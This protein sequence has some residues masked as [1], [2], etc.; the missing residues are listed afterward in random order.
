MNF[1]KKQEEY[2]KKVLLENQY[3][4]ENVLLVPSSRPDLG[5]YQ[6][7][8]MMALAKKKG[9]NPS[10]AAQK[11]ANILSKNEDYESVS[12]AGP[13]FINITFHNSA[14]LKEAE[15]LLTKESL[16]EPL[17]KKKVVIDY[18]GPNVAKI[19]H[20]GHLRSANIGES[21]KRLARKLG[22][23]VIGDIH[24]GDYGLQ[25][26]L[27]MLEIQTRYPHISCFQENFTG[28]AVNDL[29]ITNEDLLEIYPIASGK[30]KTDPE[31]LEQARAITYQFQHDHKGYKALWRSIMNISLNDMKEVYQKLN[32]E[33]DLWKGESDAEA[34]IP[35]MLEYLRKENMTIL[36]EGA[37][38]IEVKEP[39][40][41]LEIPPLLLIKSNQT[42]SYETTDLATLWDRTHHIHPDEI[43]Y[44]AD[45]RQELHFTQVFRAAYK[46]QIIPKTTKLEFIGFGTMNGLDGRPFK[47]RDGGVM[48]LRGL[49]N[50]VEKATEEKIIPSITGEERKKVSEVIAVGTLKFADL[51]SHRATDYIFDLDKFSDAYG[52]TGPFILY[53]TVRMRS[54]LKKAE[55]ENMT[56]NFLELKDKTDKKVLLQIL[57]LQ[58]VLE[59]SLQDKSLHEI[60]DYLYSLNNCYNNFYGENRIL[61]EENSNLK[62]TW[63]ALTKLVYEINLFLLDI[64]AIEVPTRM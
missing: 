58:K 50:E 64:L 46:T 43:W 31:F 13:G 16:I 45:K 4:I 63:I 57:N 44:V 2:I 22:Y 60:A 33:F 14:L 34:F 53:S 5:E 25:M 9:E 55:A 29:P 41:K 35:E 47:T 37:E 28:E 7:N 15:H 59:S 24:L 18:G 19:L 27:V 48:S 3:S 20:V 39:T 52:K 62:K 54:L 12:V 6:F 23:E 11:I 61:T 17:P 1:I 8:G 21:L 30:S 26:G 56:F 36:S 49:M 38:I 10:E 32:V 42:V 51:L 40:D